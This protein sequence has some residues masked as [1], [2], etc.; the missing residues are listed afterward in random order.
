MN[1]LVI[2]LKKTRVFE[3]FAYFAA[4]RDNFISL[5]YARADAVRTSL[6]ITGNNETRKRVAVEKLLNHIV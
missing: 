6:D 3:A 1:L 2:R 4:S 5:T